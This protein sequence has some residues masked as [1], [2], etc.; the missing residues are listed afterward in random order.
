MLFKIIKNKL[1]KYIFNSIIFNK[2]N[3][4]L[5]KP[6]IGGIPIAENKNIK[7]IIEIYLFELNNKTISPI[8]L[9]FIK[10]LLFRKLNNIIH[11]PIVTTLYII[12]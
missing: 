9:N 6:N 7:K 1:K 5:K 8:S 11:K 3:N 2:I 12:K 10:L 4:L